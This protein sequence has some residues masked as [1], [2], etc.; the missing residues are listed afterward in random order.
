MNVA[1]FLEKYYPGGGQ[2]GRLT[3][4]KVL[5]RFWS[6]VAV[7]GKDE[8]WLYN[9]PRNPQGY[10]SFSTGGDENKRHWPAHRFSW[11]LANNEIPPDHMVV[12]HRCD[13]PQ[14]LFLGTTQD[15]IR[16]KINKERHARGSIQASSKLTES[17]IPT[18]FALYNAGYTSE[19]IGLRYGVTYQIIMRVLKKE[20]WGH[21]SQGLSAKVR[22]GTPKLTWQQVEEI[23]EMHSQG[24]SI[25][26]L[27]DRYGISYGNMEKIVNGRIWRNK[28]S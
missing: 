26:P 4:Q 6:K 23:R 16:D 20:L 3:L 22:R 9:G 25:K 7:V 28:Q 21:A 5:T 11:A 24:A 12:C 10:G 8:C 18:V 13:N 2:R 27:A 15:N 19:H 14:H 1:D 17:D